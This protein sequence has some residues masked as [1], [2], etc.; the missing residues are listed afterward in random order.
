M[1][2]TFHFTG[3]EARCVAATFLTPW[4]TQ[5]GGDIWPAAL[6]VSTVVMWSCVDD[7]TL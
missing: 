5:Q 6:T 1:H 4:N 3:K 2:Q 7:D